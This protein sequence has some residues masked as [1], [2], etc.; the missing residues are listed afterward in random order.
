MNPFLCVTIKDILKTMKLHTHHYLWNGR[1]E[2]GLFLLCNVIIRFVKACEEK[3]FLLCKLTA[4]T[5]EVEYS[6]A[7]KRIQ[8]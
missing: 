1:G 6:Y 5:F 4:D 2:N 3:N 7:V 8:N